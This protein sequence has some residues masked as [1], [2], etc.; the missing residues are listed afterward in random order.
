VSEIGVW[1]ESNT[2]GWIVALAKQFPEKLVVGMEIRDKVTA[3]VDD[4]IQKLRKQS[5]AEG[6]VL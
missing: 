4:R 2:S 3:Y 5:A 1:S 6:C